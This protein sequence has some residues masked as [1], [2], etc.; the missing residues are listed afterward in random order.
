MGVSTMIEGT[1]GR[2]EIADL[3][4]FL[5][6]HGIVPAVIS[7]S[8][9]DLVRAIVEHRYGFAGFPVIGMLPVLEGGRY[10]TELRAPAPY[11]PGKV[12][13]ARLLAHEVTGSEETRP[14]LCAGDTNTDLEMLA[15]AAGCRLFFDRGKRPLMNLAEHLAAEG[16]GERTVVQA[17]FR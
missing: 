16:E 4:S 3:W 10:G 17:P 6:A 12:A 1:T 11:R 2:P 9:V 8:H 14:F 15:Y 5:S 7:A 13:A